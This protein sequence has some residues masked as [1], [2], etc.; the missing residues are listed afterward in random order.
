[1]GRDQAQVLSALIQDSFTPEA[2]IDVRLR[3]V[4]ATVIQGLLSGR[5]PDCLL[6]TSR[7]EPVNLAMRGAL[8]D[9]SAFDDFKDVIGRFKPGACIPYEYKGGTYALP[10]TQGFFM[11]FARTD[12]LNSMGIAVPDT[13]NEFIDAGKLLARKNLQCALPYT[14]I[15]DMGLL[16]IG[17]GGLSLLPTLMLQNGQ[18]LYNAG[19]SKTTLSEAKT[20]EI[21]AF[22]T[23]FY[24]KLQYP[25]SLDFYNR[26]R[27]G[28]VPLGVQ[29]YIV[30][31]TLKDAA[32]E[33][34]GRWEMFPVPGTAR[35]DGGINRFAADS[36]N[37]CVIL[38]ASKRKDAAWEFLKWWTSAEAQS[39]FCRNVES[40]LGL[41]GRVA[42]SNVEALRSLSWDSDALESLEKQWENVR[43]L[44]ELPGG[45]YVARGIDQIYWNTVH[46]NGD[47]ADLMLKWGRIV[48]L[49]I[50]RKRVQYDQR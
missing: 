9:L 5:G 35:E 6:Q 21:F 40:A 32:P 2:G 49:E 33:I 1:M 48:D 25:V 18:S 39:R 12:I 41:L 8:Y 22:W 26:F 30:Y 29:P 23:D 50:A 24:T 37:G 19:L 16:N 34:E 38:N 36:G 11:L 14:Q 7:S 43:E 31:A 28:T 45:Y 15:T 4:N 44:P 46:S 27:A 42:T 10:D 17:V 13:W 47:M 3:L 20:N